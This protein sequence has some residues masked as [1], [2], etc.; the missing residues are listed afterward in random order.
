MS[1][2]KGVSIERFEVLV[3]ENGYLIRFR[4]HEGEVP[5]MWAFETLDSMVD[6]MRKTLK[7]Y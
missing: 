3:V 2:Q 4:Y 7:V 1:I 5:I 6:W